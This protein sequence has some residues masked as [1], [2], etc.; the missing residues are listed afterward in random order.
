MNKDGFAKCVFLPS[1]WLHRKVLE[2]KAVKHTEFHCCHQYT[3]T[4][5]WTCLSILIAC[6]GWWALLSWSPPKM[7]F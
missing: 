7:S 2:W 5:C 1:T 3:G 6:A 4:W